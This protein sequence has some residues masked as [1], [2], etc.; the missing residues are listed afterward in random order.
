MLEA[1]IAHYLEERD[2]L[3]T[4]QGCAKTFVIAKQLCAF[5]DIPLPSIQPA[6]N[7]EDWVIE[8]R[9]KIAN[10]RFSELQLMAYMLGA[11]D[12]MLQT[13]GV[14][15]NPYERFM[16]LVKA[17]RINKQAAEFLAEIW[18]ISSHQQKN[19]FEN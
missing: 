4:V 9:N 6:F 19:R 5:Y 14:F 13:P 15:D 8:L 11:I 16:Q 18:A 12:Y 1:A 3:E 10:R 7:E 2:N 17:K